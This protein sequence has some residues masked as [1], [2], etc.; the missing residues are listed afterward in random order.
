MSEDEAGIKN[1]GSRPSDRGAPRS[2]LTG[3]GKSQGGR[4]RAETAKISVDESA[5]AAYSREPVR[6]TSTSLFPTSAS[7]Q[8][9][10]HMPARKSASPQKSS[11]K[12]AGKNA[13]AGRAAK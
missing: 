13:A 12:P 10:T 2:K 3:R 11:S 5:G 7:L 1:S 6:I 4:W 9:E 8:Q